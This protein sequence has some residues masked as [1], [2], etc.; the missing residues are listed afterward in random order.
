LLFVIGADRFWLGALVPPVGFFLSAQSLPA[1][2]RWWIAK[3][4]RD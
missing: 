1:I 4:F 2:K 3:R